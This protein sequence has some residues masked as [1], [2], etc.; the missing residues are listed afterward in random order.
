MGKSSLII[1]A[2]KKLELHGVSAV[3]IDLQRIGSNLDSER[4]YATL[5][6]EIG[7]PLNLNQ[8]LLAKWAE[9]QHFGSMARFINTINDV[10]LPNLSQPL[11]V[12]IDEIDF[13]RALPFNADEFF[14]GLR[15]CYN[16]R[17]EDPHYEKLTFCLVGTSTPSQLVADVSIT[18]FNIGTEIRLTD[19]ARQDL[20][21]FE[22]TYGQTIQGKQLL[23]TIYYWTSGHPYLTQSICAATF[24]SPETLR[25]AASIDKYIKHRF[26]SQEAI[27]REPNLMDVSR[28]ILEPISTLDPLEARAQVLNSYSQILNP[29]IKVIS[30]GEWHLSTLR[31]S[32]AITENNGSLAPRNRIYST[33]FNQQWIQANLP[34]AEK[35]R[36]A[37]AA[38]QATLKS[39]ALFTS[40]AL[41]LLSSVIA[42]TFLNGQKEQALTRVD[43]LLKENQ[44]QT[45][46]SQLNLLTKE[47][48]DQNWSRVSDSLKQIQDSPNKGWEYDF[49]LRKTVS[50]SLK[51]KIQR[52]EPGVTVTPFYYKEVLY[53][54]SN[55]KVHPVLSS[56]TAEVKTLQQ[57]LQ[58]HDIRRNL[59]PLDRLKL[60]RRFDSTDVQLVSPSRK[61]FT[62]IYSDDSLWVHSVSGQRFMASRSYKNRQPLFIEDQQLCVLVPNATGIRGNTMT[63]LSLID[64][65]TKWSLTGDQVSNGGTYHAKTKSLIVVTNN[66]LARVDPL[67]GTW[68]KPFKAQNPIPLAPVLSHDGN[69]L[70]LGTVSGTIEVRDANSY[71]LIQVLL[72]LESLVHH[73]VLS[74]SGKHLAAMDTKG[75]IVEWTFPVEPVPRVLYSHNHEI[76]DSIITQ[77]GH[78]IHV[79]ANGLVVAVNIQT[80]AVL[81]QKT[82][83]P[84]ENHFIKVHLP[85]V[86]KNLFVADI[87]GT[88]HEIEPLTGRVVSK[89]TGFKG[90]CLSISV[91][92]DDRYLAVS[93][94]E[95][96]VYIWDR[97]LDKPTEIKNPLENESSK[98]SWQVLF[99]SSPKNVLYFIRNGGV[100]SYDLAT[101]QIREIVKPDNKSRSMALNGKRS[102]LAISSS[103]AT[104][105]VD[106]ATNRISSGSSS[107]SR[108]F[109]IQFSP[110]ESKLLVHSFDGIARLYDSQTLN[111]IAAMKHSGW[112][113]AAAF[114]PNGTRIATSSDDKLI[115]IFDGRTGEH[116]TTLASHTA[117]VFDVAWSHDGR[118][119]ISAS[120]DGTSKVWDAGQAFPP[121]NN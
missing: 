46:V 88:V 97:Q 76:A 21:A 85:S 24:E 100:Y 26:I 84:P 34:N 111:E 43:A 78:A 1:R 113:S 3:R 36:V 92:Q 96:D 11:V 20:T 12:F 39:F 14:V 61:Y 60:P 108:N 71:R 107:I 95:G 72:G 48:E 103:Q 19:F 99:G 42:L 53:Y 73:V 56:T 40:I 28:R 55:G 54:S 87:F 8:Q 13:V 62:S 25:D 112:V 37:A 118:Y 116:L 51:R 81:W 9:D 6:H 93:T 66:G 77:D 119:L 15:S 106:L 65:A 27:Q 16:E 89:K 18:P 90:V 120:T 110:D 117:T 80:G 79:C 98:Q 2:A 70:Y 102:K 29:R 22:S 38:R 121:K 69:H 35:L 82:F 50:Y 10:L 115:R 17:A 49:W 32:G 5:L 52:S 68:R 23:D 45:Y 4:W 33:T 58:P 59:I 67:T 109:G 30:G 94:I 101:F 74:E 41:L 83:Q 86:G 105:L 57:V 63:A 91:S 44:H 47:S 64:G 114:S 104:K 7:K 75:N 31:L